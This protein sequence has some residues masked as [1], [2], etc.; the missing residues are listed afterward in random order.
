M[1]LTEDVT[2]A[3]HHAI[4]PCCQNS[5]KQNH[6]PRQAHK[7]PGVESFSTRLPVAIPVQ[8]VGPNVT[9]WYAGVNS[10]TLADSGGE[11]TPP[12]YMGPM[13][14]AQ[15]AGH[16]VLPGPPGSGMENTFLAQVCKHMR[17]HTRGRICSDCARTSHSLTYVR[18][19]GRM[20][21]HAGLRCMYTTSCCW[22][23]FCVNNFSILPRQTKDRRKRILHFCQ[24]CSLTMSGWA[25][26]S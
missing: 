7:R 21:M 18:W 24:L 22:F 11:G 4:V 2:S 10:V 9:G 20:L 5:Y 26:V 1:S 19:Y 12:N 8:W 13:H 15:T 16:G 6:W 23:Y 3:L 25:E 17:T 14:L